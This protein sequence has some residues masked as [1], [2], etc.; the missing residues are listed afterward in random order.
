MPQIYTPYRQQPSRYLGFV[1][2]TESDPLEYAATAKSLIR[3][4]DP[5]QPL[6]SI[7][8]MKQIIEESASIPR[9]ISRT[10]GAL[11]VFALILAAF[12]IYSV[13]SYTTS[14]RTNEI[15][16]RLAFGAQR[17]DIYRM[18]LKHGLMCLGI[19]LCVGV[20]GALAS[21]KFLGNLLYGVTPGDFL[22]YAGTGII[23]FAAGILAMLLP[24]RRAVSID[25]MTAIRYE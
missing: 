3:S 23:L 15:G 22:S 8:S 5:E 14:E 25:P 16:I 21:M 11:S 10:M 1:A 24:L 20:I 12:G 2:R 6:L 19:G 18:I 9:A 4:V 7:G 17:S 13:V